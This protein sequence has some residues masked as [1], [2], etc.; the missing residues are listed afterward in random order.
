LTIEAY[1]ERLLRSDE[2]AEE[3]LERLALEGLNSGELIE[4][5]SEYWEEQDR[6]L[7]RTA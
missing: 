6:R 1:V 7:D 4:I 5:T 2:Q 3:A